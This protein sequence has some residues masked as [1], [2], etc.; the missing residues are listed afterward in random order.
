[1]LRMRCLHNHLSNQRNLTSPALTR[2]VRVQTLGLEW[3]LALHACARAKE[4]G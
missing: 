4:K 1:M 2:P 3:K